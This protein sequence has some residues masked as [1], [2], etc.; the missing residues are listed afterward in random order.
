MCP[1]LYLALF[2]TINPKYKQDFSGKIGMEYFITKLLWKFEWAKMKSTSLTAETYVHI[3][4]ELFWKFEHVKIK[5][6]SPINSTNVQ[7]NVKL[8]WKFELGKIKSS[9]PI[10][11]TNVQIHVCITIATNSTLSHCQNLIKTSLKTVIEDKAIKMIPRLTGSMFL[12]V[13]FLPSINE[14]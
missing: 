3:Q 10:N 13:Y 8:L 9:S 1:N 12:Q 6:S 2:V 5:S 7:I 14:V 11:A 4:V